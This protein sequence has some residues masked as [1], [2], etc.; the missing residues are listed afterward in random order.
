MVKL[1]AILLCATLV[2]PGELKVTSKLY[3][4]NDKKGISV[5][6]GNVNILRDFDELNTST[7]TIFTDKNRK[8]LKFVAEG[9]VSFYIVT[10][11]NNSYAGK[12]KKVIYKT[13]MKEY[14]FEGNVH[15][16]QLNKKKDIQGEKVLLNLVEGFA[17]AQGDN[18]KPVRMIFEIDDTNGTL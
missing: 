9:G 13:K 1:I 11:N 4:G 6:S 2:F 7:L 10:D 3:E 18:N 14:I 15:L 8:P 16:Q 17:K 5:F 12:A